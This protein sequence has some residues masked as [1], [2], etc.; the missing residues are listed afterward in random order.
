MEASKAVVPVHMVEIMEEHPSLRW[1]SEPPVLTSPAVPAVRVVAN[2]VE[3][4][5]VVLFP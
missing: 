3:V 4:Q 5:E 2:L 1:H